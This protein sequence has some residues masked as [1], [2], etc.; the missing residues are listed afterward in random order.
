[1]KLRLKILLVTL[2][3]AIII[4]TSTAVITVTRAKNMAETQANE[5]T[6]AIAAQS[7]SMVSEIFNNSINSARGL[8][9]SIEVMVRSGVE[10]RELV[11]DMTRN[12]LS[13]EQEIFGAFV[14]FE[15]NAFDNRDEEY[16][17]TEFHDSSGRLTPYLYRE[18]GDIKFRNLD[19]YDVEGANDYYVQPMITKN[20]YITEPTEYDVDGKMVMVTSLTVPIIHDDKVIGIVGVDIILEKLQEIVTGIRIYD[21]GIGSIISNSGTV[22]AHPD[23]NLIGNITEELR[24]GQEDDIKLYRNAIN[25]GHEYSAI[26]YSE[27]LKQEVFKS[28]TPIIIGNTGLPWSFGTTIT[29]GDMYKEVNEQTLFLI[30]VM[31]VGLIVLGAIIFFITGYITKPMILASE[32][33]EKIGNLD[34]RVD[35][36]EKLLE[37]KDEIGNLMKSFNKLGNNLKDIIQQIT[38][39]SNNLTSS[40]V[41]LNQIAEQSAMAAEEVSKTIEGIAMGASDQAVDTENSAHHVNDMNRLLDEEAGLLGELNKRT[42]EIEEQK[43]LGFEIIN[44]LID[45]TKESNDVI[46]NIYEV[47]LNNNKSAEKIENASGMIENIAEQTNLLALNAAIEAAR[48]GEAGKGFADVAD[49]IR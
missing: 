45:K 14:G 24:T 27:E 31:S 16:K 39:S 9:N 26:S 20:E 48:A 18:G 38:S 41:S 44:V 12:M 7:S 33:A 42:A 22:V 21:E 49:E 25:G 17:N 8:A 47:I 13:K 10:D 35:V 5:L 3:A 11:I 19:S 32:Y 34:L 28:M 4:F 15:P 30:L 6:K 2:L 37:R 36:D 46:E 29:E 23:D 43:Q 1:M 40:S